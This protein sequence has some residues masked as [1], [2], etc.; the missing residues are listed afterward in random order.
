MKDPSAL[1]VDLGTMSLA[2]LARDVLLSP[3]KN[4]GRAGRDWCQAR[5]VPYYRDGKRNF[6][7][8]EDVRKALAKIRGEQLNERAEAVNDAIA[9]MLRSA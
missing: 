9:S 1:D 8:T 2:K 6:V 5:N 7:R 3:A 4:L